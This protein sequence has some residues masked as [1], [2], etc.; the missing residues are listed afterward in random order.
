MSVTSNHE[1]DTSSTQ[2][3]CY[4]PSLFLNRADFLMRS[5]LQLNN[6]V[7]VLIKVVEVYIVEDL[8]ST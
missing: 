3:R 6:T 7:E 1:H 2:S 8:K 5:R 4:F